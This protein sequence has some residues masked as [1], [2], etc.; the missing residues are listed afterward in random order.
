MLG[1]TGET[2][3]ELATDEQTGPSFRKHLR[4]IAFIAGF[5]AVAYTVLRYLES[6]K[7]GRR[8]REANSDSV[9]DEQSTAEPVQIDIPETETEHDDSSPSGTD[10]ETNTR[11]EE[12]GGELAEEE[13]STEEI[14]ERSES[15]IQEEPAEPGEMTVDDDVADELVDDTDESAETDDDRASDND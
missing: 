4:D 13:R 12:A 2:D 9:D 10:S 8:S 1:S 6:R 15:D 3:R 5:V 11:R 14:E 7:D